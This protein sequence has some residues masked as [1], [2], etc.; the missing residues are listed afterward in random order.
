MSQSVM[1][2]AK[3][4][5]SLVARSCAFGEKTACPT[6]DYW[7]IFGT[8]AMVSLVSASARTENNRKIN[9]RNKTGM[10]DVMVLACIGLLS[11]I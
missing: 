2:L 5:V 7:P 11:P 9:G 8:T 10:T 3:S 4:S 6:S 1:L